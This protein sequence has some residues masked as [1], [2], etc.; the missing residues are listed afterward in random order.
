MEIG[1]DFDDSMNRIAEFKIV[2]DLITRIEWD[3]LEDKIGR[4]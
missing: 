4:K 3:R 1:I 2:S